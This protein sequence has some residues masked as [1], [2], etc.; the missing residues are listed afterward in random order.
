VCAD[1]HRRHRRRLVRPALTPRSPALR[2]TESRALS[3][4]GSADDRSRTRERSSS[5]AARRSVSHARAILVPRAPPTIGLARETDR[6]RP[7]SAA[8]PPDDR[9][10]SARIRQER[11]SSGGG[12]ANQL[13]PRLF[14]R[15]PRV[16][17]WP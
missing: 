7:G 6:R 16:L 15:L 12:T 17:G 3:A 8:P 13:T 14:F 10:R 2:D 9:S 5:P 1:L 4:P 11:Q